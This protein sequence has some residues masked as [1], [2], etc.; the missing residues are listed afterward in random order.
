MEILLL[1][2]THDLSDNLSVYAQTLMGKNEVTDRR[3]NISFI[4]TWAPRVFS[5]NFYLPPAPSLLPTHFD[6]G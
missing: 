3:E 4:L 5:D 6:I 1:H 2:Y